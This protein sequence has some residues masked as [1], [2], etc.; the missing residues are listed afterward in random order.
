MMLE[1]RS[2]GF[3]LVLVYIGTQN[4]EINLARIR[5]RV[6]AGGRDVPEADVRRRYERRF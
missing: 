2:T 1:A 4:V 5:N 3:E 6:L